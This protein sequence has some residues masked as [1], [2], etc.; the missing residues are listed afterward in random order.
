M[1][2]RQMET[3]F[4]NDPYILRLKALEKLLFNY[5]IM[6]DFIGLTG[7]YE[8]PDMTIC[9]TLGVTLAE[10]TKMKNK[11]TAD[12]KFIFYKEWVY[13][14]NYH[15]YNQFSCAKSI[16]GAFVKEFNR[17]PAPI[18]CKLF[19]VKKIKYIPPISNYKKNIFFEVT[20]M[21]KDNDNVNDNDKYPRATL[22]A[23]HQNAKEV[24]LNE[25]VDPDSIPL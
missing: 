15:K 24:F 16:L 17:I 7:I 22:A 6:N 5:L 23:V 25:N 8:L 10:L 12:N 2:Y 18:L 14:V 4:W 3:R 9:Y 1:R 11:F 13:V 20:D 19:T 21:V